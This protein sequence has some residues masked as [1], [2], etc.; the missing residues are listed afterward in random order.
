MSL[1]QNPFFRESKRNRMQYEYESERE[2][3]SILQ[4]PQM[5]PL[6][7]AEHLLVPVRSKSASGASRSLE[8]GLLRRPGG[9]TPASR[10]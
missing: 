2:P 10:R 3:R 9:D 7:D 5:D 8:D 4:V 1:L 6:P